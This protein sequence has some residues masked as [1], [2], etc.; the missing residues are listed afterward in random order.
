MK[1]RA[2]AA[3]IAIILGCSALALAAPAHAAP[4]A[5]VLANLSTS[6][7]GHLTGTASSPGAPVLRFIFEGNPGATP[8]YGPTAVLSGTSGTFDVPTW[9]SPGEITVRVV[10]CALQH[11]SAPSLPHVVN[12]TDVA[13]TVTWPSD[14]TINFKTYPTLSVSDPDGGGALKAMW[15][16]TDRDEFTYL[17][18][19]ARSG[20]SQLPFGVGPGR[21][22]LYRCADENGYCSPLPVSQDFVSLGWP[23]LTSTAIP[24]LTQAKPTATATLSA[25]LDDVDFPAGSTFD[26]TWAVRRPSGTT[27]LSGTA[28]GALTAGV[29]VVKKIAID[30]RSWAD[31]TLTLS[32]HITV[33]TADFGD[34]VNQLRNSQGDPVT[35][36]SNTQGPRLTS[37]T[38]SPTT[39]YPRIRTTRYP[40]STTVTAAT[41][42]P[43]LSKVVVT[44][45][46][47]TIAT[48]TNRYF[49]GA[50]ITASWNGR[51]YDGSIAAAGRYRLYALDNDGNRSTTYREVVVSGKTL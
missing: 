17:L 40:G 18:P 38:V 15:D 14:T 27:L 46:S 49:Q 19:V 34:L 41:A 29:N 6:T 50:K 22:T 21:V 23:R 9:G 4:A 39:I 51:K 28:S 47:K 2:I 10:A 12:P 30:A 1:P 5:P 45:G 43:E 33:H 11:C 13:P 8:Y 16:R 25:A 32:G 44:Y 48:L 37:M 35:F 20:S 31:G 36:T 42:T 7:P 3:L 24:T 26:L